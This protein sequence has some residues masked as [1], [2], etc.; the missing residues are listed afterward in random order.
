MTFSFEDA[1]VV[2]IWILIV[3]VIVSSESEQNQMFKSVYYL[4]IKIN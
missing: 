1:G 2:K 4:P 3:N